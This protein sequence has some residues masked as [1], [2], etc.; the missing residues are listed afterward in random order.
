MVTPA[1]PASPGGDPN[2]LQPF[3]LFHDAV[4][5][6]TRLLDAAAVGVTLSIVLIIAA[7]IVAGFGAR[8]SPRPDAPTWEQT[9]AAD[10]DWRD[11]LDEPSG[12]RHHTDRTGEPW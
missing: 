9:T 6:L 7:G 3:Q 8:R 12:G 2:G 10:P 11:G 4:T 5:F 1:S